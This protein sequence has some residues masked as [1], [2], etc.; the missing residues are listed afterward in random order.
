MIYYGRVEK[1]EQI[2]QK[3][4]PAKCPSCGN[5]EV[6]ELFFYQKEVNSGYIINMTKKVSGVLYCHHTDTEIP[7]VQWSDRIVDYFETEKTKQK[8]LPT[9]R[10]WNKKAFRIL[11][12][13]MIPLLL[14]FSG[15]YVYFKYIDPDDLLGIQ[16]EYAEAEVNDKLKVEVHLFDNTGATKMSYFKVNKIVEDTVYIQ[17]HRSSIENIDTLNL[18]ATDFT[19]KVFKV[20]YDSFK[21]G[22]LTEWNSSDPPFSGFTK[23]LIKNT[24]Q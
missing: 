1:F 15:V 19:S 18:K 6:L 21:I 22:Y 5:S 9:G 13:L 17:Q 24:N 23:K 3:R 8:L 16:E 2:G 7:P 20:R 12:I 10:R 4:I 11:A 14:L